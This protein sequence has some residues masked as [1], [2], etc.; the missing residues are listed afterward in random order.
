MTTQPPHETPQ[1]GQRGSASGAP[2]RHG[3]LFDVLFVLVLL[4]GAQLRCG[5]EWRADQLMVCEGLTWDEGTY[6]HPDERFL[7]IVESKLEPVSSFSEYW[8]TQTSTL[9]PNNKGEGFFVYGTLPIFFVRYVMEWT[10]NIGY[11]E[12]WKIGRPLAGVFDLLTI[13]FLYMAA[14]RLYGRRV[15]LL[16][17]AFS[18]FAVL[19][20]QLSHFFTVD[21]FANAFIWAAIYFGIRITTTQHIPEPHKLILPPVAP[22]VDLAPAA[23]PRPADEILPVVRRIL[24]HPLLV[25]FLLFGIL[26]G[27][28]A[29]SKISAFPVAFLLPVAAWIY[30]NKAGDTRETLPVLV[31]L[32][33]AGFFAAL[34]FRV[35]QPYA[36]A[37]PGF[38]NVAFN[39]HWLETIGRLQELV[40]PSSGFPPSVQWF[41]RPLWFSGQHL[42]VW[43]LGLPLGLAAW[44]GFIW[45]GIRILRGAWGRHGLVWLWVG[46]HFIWQSLAPNPTMRYQLPIYPG[47]ALMAAWGLTAF[48]DWARGSGRRVSIWRP[49]AG[50]LGAAVLVLT[51]MYAAAFA[52][53]YASGFED[54]S[55]M[56]RL[57]GSRWIYENVPGAFTLRIE[58][59]A[60]TETRLLSFPNGAALRPGEPFNLPFM[61]QESGSL[62]QI[63][64][65]HLEPVIFSAAGSSLYLKLTEDVEGAP[66]LA[67]VFAG[68]DPLLEAEPGSPALLL[69]LDSQ[70]PLQAFTAYR[71][72]IELVGT[73]GSVEVCEPL[74][75][76]VLFEGGGGELEAPPPADCLLTATAPLRFIVTPEADL[77]LDTIL[78]SPPSNLRLDVEAQTITLE[79]WDAS[80]AEPAA[81]STLEI[82]SPVE[83][84][85]FQLDRSVDLQAGRGYRVQISLDRGTPLAIS[86]AVLAQESSW[87]DPL[88]MR[89]DGY[90]GYGG[91]YRGESNLELYWPDN[92]EKVDRFVRVLD[93]VDYIPISSSR[94]WASLTRLPEQ[95]P[96]VQA[97]YRGLMGCPDDLTVEICFNIAEPGM[98]S[99][100]LGFELVETFQSNPT[101]FGFEINDQFSEEAFTVYDHPKVFIFEKTAAYDPAFV[102]AYFGGIALPNPAAAGSPDT[103]PIKPL[104]LSEDRRETQTAAGTWSDLFDTDALLN[105]SQ[106]LAVVVWYLTI[107]LLGLAVYP[108]LVL[109]MPGLDDKG[110]PFARTVGLLL[111]AYVVWLPGSLGVPITR[112]VLTAA[113][114]I[115]VICGLAAFLFTRENLGKAWRENRNY[116]LSVEGLALALFLLMLFIRMMN[117]DLWHPWKGGEKPMDF[118]YFNAVLKSIHFPPYDPWFAGGYINY[119]YYGYVIVGTVVKWLGIVPAV[120]YN[121]IIP[122]LFMLVGT[123]AFSIAWNL[124]QARRMA[125]LPE[126]LP[127]YRLRP[128][129][130]AGPEDGDQAIEAPPPPDRRPYLAGFAA[131]IGVTILGNLGSVRMILQ[132]Y[133]R[134]AAPS[135]AVLDETFFLTRWIWGLRGFVEVLTTD[136]NFP[137]A[138][139]DWYW[140]PSRAIPAPGD[141]EPIT[142]FPFF[143]FLYGDLHAHMIALPITLFAIAWALSVVLG[144]GRWRNIPVALLSFFIGGL[145]IGALRPTNT[146]DYPT[147]LALGMLA[148]GYTG[149]R[150]AAPAVG[151]RFAGVPGWL[152]GVLAAV[153]G[154]LWLA[155]LSWY[156]YQPYTESYALGYADINLWENT[157]TSLSAYLTHW[158]LFLVVIIAWM[159]WETREWLAATPAAAGLRFLRSRIEFIAAGL[160]IAVVV[161]AW[162]LY[163]EVSLGV[164]LIPLMAW[165]GLLLFRPGIS[166]RKRIVLFMVG[167]GVFLTTMV[168]TIVL[169][170]D[171][172]RMNTVFKFYLQVWTLFG[173]SAAVA[174]AWV[175]P[176]TDR[177]LPIWNRSWRLVVGSLIAGACL[178]PLLGGF[179]RMRDRVD[180]NAPITL[181]GMAY[182]PYATYFE[183]GRE[184]FFVE[185]Y[186][187]IR[188]MQENVEG[189]PVIV[190][191][192]VVEYRWGA[193]YSIYTGLP[194]VLGWNWHQRQQRTGHDAD[195]WARDNLPGGVDDFYDTTNVNIA[196]QFLDEHNVEYII[197][198]QMERAYNGGPG[199]DKFETFDGRYWQEVY[200]DGET[201]IYRVIEG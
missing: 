22:D 44:G 158:G 110:Y 26:T 97:F 56:S 40:Q 160:L 199:I 64:V 67:S 57:E 106:P 150:Y 183:E 74:R 18:A 61:P 148:V 173:L 147:Y 27:A 52:G 96:L 41:D 189:T 108:I 92:L 133:Q 200:R 35:F 17:G 53:I 169:S 16:A 37:G 78:L 79:I 70:V 69:S 98:F 93:Q 118:A 156:L 186:R 155:I 8:N 30:F 25:P 197:V 66:V 174:L 14:S 7:A 12:V 157:H 153:T 140:N 90:D 178:Y 49:V 151:N 81:I 165:T 47:M 124:V 48:W 10:D 11:G 86:G 145:A 175:I 117:P 152:A 100:V 84:A 134:V 112:P 87:D 28:A 51:L 107:F 59:A 63:L 91:I 115:L 188:W 149:W 138:L 161:I 113:L 114:G 194:T 5:L 65:P 136:A 101:L 82:L 122:T 141:I 68:L 180:L 71:I 166:D 162:L 187:A 39:P 168:E 171:I 77:T 116:F 144:R 46:G 42:T 13:V 54:R 32:A 164:F 177:W 182:M 125:R 105:R 60:G 109:A 137:Y 89:V 135:G 29:A 130:E 38:F 31:M 3:F 195:V 181:D 9:N 2:A 119:Y 21:I 185:D 191:G 1:E 43:G 73:N 75:L 33:G 142:E 83:G 143:T 23:D 121:L 163:L 99:G 131:A 172:G 6:L 139:P 58:G 34:T 129:G 159:A 198:G 85:V 123:G 127:I 201:V 190:E 193:R 102:H 36:F 62:D 154:V 88:P 146:W 132:G 76:L 128:V 95:W 72:E 103:D 80:G 50:L 176:E 120:A 15:G 170:G 104:T 126:S 24:T 94:Q 167:T 192:Q 184:L 55:E 20:I 19:Q 111:L 196:L 4:I 45:M 179:A